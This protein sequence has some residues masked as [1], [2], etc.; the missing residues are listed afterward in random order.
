MKLKKIT[1]KKNRK[2]K[3]KCSN[4]QNVKSDQRTY[5]HSKFSLLE[6]QHPNLRTEW[7]SLHTHMH[8]LT[9][10]SQMVVVI[11][12]IANSWVVTFINIKCKHIHKWRQPNTNLTEKQTLVDTTKYVRAWEQFWQNRNFRV[13]IA[14]VME[15]LDTSTCNKVKPVLCFVAQAINRSVNRLIGCLAHWSNS[16]NAKLVWSVQQIVVVCIVV[17]VSWK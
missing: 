4:N 11:T 10:K 15:A 6:L 17:A 3:T 12:T 2:T 14:I 9:S 1:V 5:K 8:W 13:F 7:N 16:T